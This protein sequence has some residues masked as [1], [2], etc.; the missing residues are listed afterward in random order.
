MTIHLLMPATFE[1]CQQT[2]EI[3]RNFFLTQ[4]NKNKKKKKQ[5]GIII[6]KK[7]QQQQHLRHSAN[8][9]SHR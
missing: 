3:K 8:D 1:I 2:P 7:K 4:K 9:V 5:E 6:I